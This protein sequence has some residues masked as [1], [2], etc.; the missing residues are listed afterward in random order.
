MHMTIGSKF[1][2]I[3]VLCSRNQTLH[4]VCKNLV[5]KWMD[6][7]DRFFLHSLCARR[8]ERTKRQVTRNNYL[9]RSLSPRETKRSTLFWSVLS[10]KRCNALSIFRDHASAFD[11]RMNRLS[12]LIIIISKPSMRQTT[13]IQDDIL[14]YCTSALLLKTKYH[15]C[16]KYNFLVH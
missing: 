7:H 6:D 10:T 4:L 11:K 2:L 3:I 14:Y 13:T 1:C 16:K 8:Q 12:H 9:L 5:D 15:N